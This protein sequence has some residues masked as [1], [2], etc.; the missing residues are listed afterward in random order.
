MAELSQ[1]HGVALADEDR[2]QDRPPADSCD[3]AQH[4]MDRRF[5]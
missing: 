3:V 1:T 5:I 4:M 2:I